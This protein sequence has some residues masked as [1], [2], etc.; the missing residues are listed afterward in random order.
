MAKVTL[1]VPD[2]LHRELKREQLRLEELGKKV[3]L[4]D[5]YYEI[6]KLGIEAKKNSL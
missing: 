3:N 1:D 5:L 2:D 6:I 4:K